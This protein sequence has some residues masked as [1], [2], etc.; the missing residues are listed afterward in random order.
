HA[1]H[2]HTWHT[3]HPTANPH[4]TTH[5][6]A[7][8]RA[9][10][11][12]RA[13]IVTDN[14]DDLLAALAALARGEPARG[15]YT[16]TAVTGKVVLVFPGQGSQWTGMGQELMDASPV[17]RDR[18][19]QCAE[20]LAPH[21]DWSPLDVLRGAP[22][23][24]PLSRVDVVQPALWAMMV[25]LAAVWRSYGVTPDA[26]VGHS[27]GE[28]AAACVAG[29]L[30][31]ED[32]ARV[33]ARRSRA[34]ATALA[35]TG[36]MASVPL[37]AGPVTER[38]ARWP[39]EL[40]V[41]AVN[42]PNATVVSGTPDALD[43]L[44]T[45]YQ[46]EGVRARRIDVDYASHSPHVA[47]LREP[48]LD[49][50]RDIAP[51]RGTIPMCSTMTG[52]L[53]DT[54]GLDA[55]YWYR[56]LRTTVRFEQAVRTLVAGGHR[57]FL[58]VSPHPVLTGGIQEI[59]EAAGAAGAAVETLRRDEG[60]P[61]RLLAS[62]A[63]AHTHGVRVDWSALLGGPEVPAVDL[64]TYPFQHRS[65]WLRPARAGADPDA[66]GVAA[67]GHPLLGAAVD[68][69]AG[70]T[71]FTGRLSREAQPWLG[72]HTVAD[73]VLMPGTALVELA[74]HA[75]H[76]A[77]HARLG[78][79]LLEEPLVLP[80]RDAVELRVTLAAPDEAGHRT[81]TVHSRPESR[82][83]AAGR[84][85][86]R[87]AL[88]VSSPGGGAT[89]AADE[90]WP[91]AG[92]DPLDLSDAYHRLGKRGYAYGPAFQGL[93][94][95]W[96]SG[97][98][99]YAEIALEGVDATG[100]RV[101]PALL[102][103]ALHPLLLEQVDREPGADEIAL[104]FAWSGV[105][106]QPTTAT[107]LRVRLTATGPG[108]ARVA[109][110]DPTG[111]P[112]ATVDE[113]ALR[114]VTPERLR[115][116]AATADSV[117]AVVWEPIT[118]TAGSPES[119]P[120]ARWAAVGAGTPVPEGAVRY[121]DLAA[122]GAAVADGA[123]APDYVVVAP[124][125]GGGAPAGAGAA[126]GD[127]DGAVAARMATIRALDLVQEWLADPRWA[128]T[129]LVVVTAGAVAVRPG[130][131]VRDL[132]AA[133]V[134]GL[135][136][137]AQAEHPDRFTLVD[138][139]PPSDL[140]PPTPAPPT[141]TVSGALL[142]VVVGG[143]EPQVAVRGGVGYA[144]RL[145][146]DP[147]P[148][149][150][151]DGGTATGWRWTTTGG[152]T[153]NDLAPRPHPEAAR[154]LAAGEIRIAVR[155]AGLNF[156]DVL[157]ALNA[158]PEE[159]LI[160]AEAAGVVLEVGAGVGAV[161]PGDRVMGMVTSGGFGPVAITDARLV[162]R[163]PPG[164]SYERAAA[165]PVAFLT[166]YYGLVDLAGVQAGE[167]V[168]VHA[169]AGGVGMA[170]VLLARHL[171]AEVF[172]TASPAKWP[173]VRALGVTGDHLA[174]S[175]TVAF[176]RQF[177]DATG[178]AG[179]DVALHSLVREY[180]DATLRA[181]PRGGRF[182]DIGKIDPRSPRE[183]ATRYPGVAY[184]ALDLFRAGPDRIQQMLAELLDL[185]ARGALR[186][187]PVTTWPM[188]RA[189]DAFRQVQRGRHVGKVVFTLPGFDPFG[190]VLLTGGTGTIGRALARH[191]I[192]RHGVRD[193]LL[194]S[195]RGPDPDLEAELRALGGRV[196]S[197]ACDAADRAALAAVLA[198][199]PA[200]RPLSA[201]IHAAGVL[202]DATLESLTPEDV[203]A[204]FRPKVDAAWHL[205][206][207]TADRALSAFV[208]FS[209]A[210]GTLGT[211]GQANYAAANAYLDA[212]AH[213]R[214]A[215]GLPATSLAWG[216]WAPASGM[217]GHLTDA[218]RARMSR[219]G[220]AAMPVEQGLELF[221]QAL[222]AGQPHLVPAWLDRAA[223]RGLA[224][225]GALPPI[226]RGLV[227]AADR[228]RLG[229]GGPGPASWLA[230]LAA[231]PAPDRAPA[232]AE[233]IRAQAAVVLGHASPAAIGPEQPLKDLGL[234]SLAAVELRNRLAA[235]TGLTL[236]AAVAFQH[237]T[238]SALAARLLPDLP[239]GRIG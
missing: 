64:P 143:G 159:A 57:L 238:V 92:A 19:A 175:R 183:V 1:H 101:H 36:G 97:V 86:T 164:W 106:L 47:A 55:D 2:H 17:F 120:V 3:N 119:P 80:E 42:G 161:A 155:A 214:R 146:P 63:A 20:A 13:A 198:R 219:A 41:A 167:R 212:L 223:L 163:I 236:P 211:V 9:H 179:V 44:V 46:A 53:I 4:H 79:F 136:R 84:T 135:V 51:A 181:M 205:H 149:I 107:V 37:P 96:R 197:V 116:A 114:P 29:A 200:D 160:G 196:R 235:A 210:A 50:L 229:A 93:R 23:A 5:T 62:V 191:L 6:L 109:V 140:A 26:V 124:T 8:R 170:A 189:R 99:T 165:V 151:T 71:V 133:P 134:W 228:E 10:L 49:A 127:E 58:E 225:R 95:A 32:A 35:G 52:E 89:A 209:S 203:E 132:A 69:V 117:L 141:P 21:V 169:A 201:V 193:L 88:G 30:S 144:P 176:E 145:R 22:E 100:Y 24:P 87:H 104:P 77:G 202:D 118:G 156:R 75:G 221:D 237:P 190:T 60:G 65:F 122:L 215:R 172:G 192:T 12:H 206:E 157:I 152:G 123:P 166:A 218:D 137:T 217:T 25:S 142:P 113:L 59:L 102:D 129:R 226:F 234:D 28:I 199:I 195:R 194:L 7:T 185:F 108:S 227:R 174:S 45:G 98:D 54:A 27:Q 184:Q 173:A 48:V 40:H 222:A 115:A 178:G 15:L 103:A 168:L 188:H 177:L 39:G 128:A 162:A 85:W 231:L 230:R 56:S 186:P 216:L 91:P 94:A 82:A 34:I 138:L 14:R 111:A 121:A 112:V 204:V 72:D 207:L 239:H 76:H 11:P 224:D 38:L 131:P 70:E 213:H 182:V 147:T 187:L 139:E 68:L 154:P 81:V 78:E 125:P 150:G 83:G 105:R 74:A 66:L 18:M 153:I 232:L 220:I 148:P 16:A 73:T 110:T 208:L 171:G 158:Y 33:V 180:T 61:A 67:T 90:A 31:I 233:L 126:V 130:E 43:A